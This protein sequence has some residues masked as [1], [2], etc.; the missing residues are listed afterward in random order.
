MK[1]LALAIPKENLIERLGGLSK[2]DPAGPAMGP[3]A[4]ET[5]DS[6]ARNSSAESALTGLYMEA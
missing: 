4:D 2:C 5:I 3:W 6:G 1:Q